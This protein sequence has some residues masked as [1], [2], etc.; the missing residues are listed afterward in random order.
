MASSQVVFKL[1][2]EGEILREKLFP[3]YPPGF[4]PKF[5]SSPTWEEGTVCPSVLV[6]K[7]IEGWGLAVR[8]CVCVEEIG[9]ERQLSGSFFSST[10]V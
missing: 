1:R 8:V 4:T 5:S 7:L 3:Q 2:S 9:R 10:P 6:S